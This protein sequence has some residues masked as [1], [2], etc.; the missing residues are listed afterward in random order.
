MANEN[1]ASYAKIG[2]TVLI[3]VF[4]IAFALV[5]FA[6]LDD[7]SQELLVETYYDTPVSGLSVGSSVNFRGVKIG[8]V[9]AIEF[10]G[11]VYNG[12]A[13]LGESQRICVLMAIMPRKFGI[14]REQSLEI[15]KGFVANGLRAT[16][17]LNG[18]TGLSRIELGI[19]DAPVELAPINW[20][21]RYLVI[22]PQPS[23]LESFSASATKLMNAANKMDFQSVWSNLSAV[24]SSTASIAANADKL[25]VEQRAGIGSIVKN[26]DEAAEAVNSLVERLKDNPSLILRSSAPDKLEE[27][28]F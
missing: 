9:R 14:S 28:D 8:E 1:R 24:A 17:A 3:G 23:L 19:P 13:N 26:I 16:V 7:R 12:V 10:F 21:P 2:F 20:T 4:A 11:R 18:V 22:P 25:L 6:G 27:T 15:L 5:Y